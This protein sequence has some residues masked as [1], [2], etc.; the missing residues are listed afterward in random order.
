MKM[1]YGRATVLGRDARLAVCRSRHSSRRSL[2]SIELHRSMHGWTIFA[3]GK[4]SGSV[5]N[6]DSSRLCFFLTIAPCGITAIFPPGQITPRT[7]GLIHSMN[8]LSRRDGGTT[9]HEQT[10]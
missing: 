10:S 7:A 9:S 3:Q 1:D 4:V 2:A 5:P 6:C 8:A